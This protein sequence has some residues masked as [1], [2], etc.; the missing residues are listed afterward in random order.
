[1]VGYL[2]L[3][4]VPTLLG[5]DPML[6]LLHEEDLVRALLLA[7]GSDAP[8][9]FNIVGSVE[10]PL[11]V[12]VRETGGRALPVMLPFL[13]PLID[14]LWR[15]RLSPAPLPHVDFLRY[16]CLLDGTR[17]RRALGYRPERD[18]RTTLDAVRSR[19]RPDERLSD[20][21]RSTEEGDLAFLQP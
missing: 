5:Y 17:A 2:R 6:Q 7:A 11:S 13:G 1:M 14:T 18:A 16:H 15:R 10:A 20:M 12:L 19:A 9:V 8:G 21:F 3:P 4:V